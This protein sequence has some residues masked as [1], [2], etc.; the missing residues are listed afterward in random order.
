MSL[1]EKKQQELNKLM[2]G[3]KLSGSVLSRMISNRIIGTDGK[4]YP[5][6]S[7]CEIITL[8]YM[9]HICDQSGY[10]EYVKI[11]ELGGLLG[12]SA[13]NT[14]HVMEGLQKKGFIEASGNSW[15]GYRAV[16]ILNN[17]YRGVKDFHGEK[18]YLN[19]NYIFFRRDE[20]EFFTKFCELSLYAM[21]TFLY[22][23]F[24]Y[25][26]RIGFHISVER[27][28]KQ[29]GIASR[30]LCLSYLKE[31]EALVGEEFCSIADSKTKRIKYDVINL[32][33]GNHML[34]ADE[35]VQEKQDAYYKYKWIIYLRKIGITYKK[36]YEFASALFGIVFATLHNEQSKLTLE[37]MEN[38][39][40]EILW[41]GG[42]ERSTLRNIQLRLV[43][44]EYT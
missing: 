36:V 18:R 16:R 5:S 27:L 42:D 32:H 33:P 44:L 25:N 14:Y 35:Q 9:T 2:G 30:Y 3:Y 12:Y 15:T 6:L 41:E 34:V 11:N 20:S 31:I 1:K 37:C 24:Q 19:T 23:L 22:L 17:N 43:E 4:E 7:K 10:I 38:V 8:L 40:K 29:L 28:R 21:R 39:I 13:R 26:V